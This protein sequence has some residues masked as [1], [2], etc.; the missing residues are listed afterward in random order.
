MLLRLKNS[1]KKIASSIL[2]IFVGGW[3]ALFCQTCFATLESNEVIALSDSEV[4][5]RCHETDGITDK[6]DIQHVLNSDR[7]SGACAC[8]DIPASLNS[9]GTVKSSDK[10]KNITFDDNIAVLSN[11]PEQQIAQTTY[12]IGIFPKQAIL[13]PLKHFTVLLI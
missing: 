8:D 13:L 7:C 5:E 1:E 9:A 10:F 12:P 3:L 11:E 6:V 4:I 2:T